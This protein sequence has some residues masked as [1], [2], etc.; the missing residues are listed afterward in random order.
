[1]TAAKRKARI[2]W[3]SVLS[4]TTLIILKLIVGW[5]TFSV[6]VI[7]EAIHSGVDLVAAIIALFAVK[8][9]SKPADSKHPYG[10]GKFE[11]IS[12]TVEALLIFVAAGWIIYEA[13]HKFG[14]ILSHQ[15][16][17][18]GHSVSWGVL[19][20]AISAVVNWVVSH[21]LFKIGKETDSVALQA[22]GW[23]LRTD[24]YTSLGV[25][26][27]LGVMVLGG[28]IFPQWK[29][30]LLLIDPI[31]AMLVACL[32]IKAAWDLTLQSA[33][34]LLDV[35]LPPEEEQWI[36]DMLTNFGPT[37]HGFHHLRT[38][39]AGANRFVDVH[40]FVDKAMTV[41]ASHK[42][43]HDLAA[44]LEARFGGTSMTVHIEPC[45]GKCGR[46][47]EELGQSQTT[48]SAL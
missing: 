38:R 33:R 19:V 6:S 17:K 41:D 23:H 5:L 48:Q 21:W 29:E 24:V 22:D 46:A 37:V 40:V 36:H 26:V 13:V 43:S 14:L 45:G 44:R 9:G 7:S 20:M 18:E 15:A 16:L 31:A 1:M 4:N 11:N 32:I 10:H 3:I 2:A 42:L 12:G 27:G 34:D 8:E 25:M 30:E 39:K 47:H 28:W 35:K